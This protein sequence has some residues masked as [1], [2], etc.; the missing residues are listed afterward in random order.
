MSNL[1]QSVLQ[2]F[3]GMPKEPRYFSDG[4]TYASTRSKTVVA[5]QLGHGN[6]ILCVGVFNN[7]PSIKKVLFIGQAGILSGRA[8][9]WAQW[10]TRPIVIMR[11][12]SSRDISWIEKSKTWQAKH[13]EIISKGDI[14][15][16]EPK[17]V[18]LFISYAKAS[19]L[20]EQ[21]NLCEWDLV[22][23]DQAHNLKNEKSARCA[24]IL[25]SRKRASLD[26]IPAKKWLF[27]LPYF[28]SPIDIWPI[29]KFCDPE[30]LG[31]SM[32][33]FAM[34]YCNARRTTYG[35]DISGSSNFDE[36]MKLMREKFW[37]TAE[38][39]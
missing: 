31:K 28:R 7:D 25:G 23:V 17:P 2:N 16:T 32:K 35:V 12:D 36:L 11:P 1:N 15:T 34:R 20:K 24:N 9:E 39:E 19:I 22:V 37:F 38:A 27:V 26:A 10:S 14:V 29:V 21:L 4:V 5:M 30:G 18:V 33:E 6:N 3:A 8:K 13:A